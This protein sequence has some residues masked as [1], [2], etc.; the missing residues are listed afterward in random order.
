MLGDVR[1]AGVGEHER[2]LPR[3]LVRADDLSRVGTAFFQ[4]NVLVSAVVMAAVLVDL[5]I[6]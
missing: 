6:G 1:A 5:W 2:A 4:L 3:R